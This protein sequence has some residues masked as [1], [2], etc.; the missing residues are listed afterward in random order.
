M[1]RKNQEA[2]GT[3]NTGDAKVDQ[4][5]L[6]LGDVSA[7]DLAGLGFDEI[8]PLKGIDAAYNAGQEG[9]LAGTTKL[10]QY[11]GTKMC[12]STVEKKPT[13]K[14][15]PDQELRDR[16]KVVRLLHHFRVVRPNG[17]VLPQVFGLWSAGCLDAM[18]KRIPVNSVLAVTYE[19]K[20]ERAF[21][22]GQ[23][24]PH[25]FKLR[26][27]GIEMRITDLDAYSELSGDVEGEEQLSQQSA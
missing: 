24:P 20:A 9:F 11:I 7:D 2:Q 15:H 1:A 13:W 17:E 16:G 14:A 5:T 21:K 19:G 22:P 8:D 10:G 3:E 4:K 23:T 6:T 12:V 25:I 26:G 18:L 27:K